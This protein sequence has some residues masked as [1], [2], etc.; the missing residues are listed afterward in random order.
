M[1]EKVKATLKFVSR[2][3]KYNVR[4][5]GES[6]F[7]GRPDIKTIYIPTTITKIGKYAFCL[8]N[9]RRIVKTKVITKL[10]KSKLKMKTGYRWWARSVKIK[11][12]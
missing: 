11:K 7:Y 12:G 9:N 3:D 6:A 4:E 10:P 8:K 5:I 1:P 2:I